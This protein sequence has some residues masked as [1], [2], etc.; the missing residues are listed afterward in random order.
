[1]AGPLAA[2]IIGAV[3][4][5]LGGLFGKSKTKNEYVVPDYA[6]I[7]SKAE[8]A[9]FN[10]LFAMANAPGQVVQTTSGGYMGNAIADASMIMADAVAKQSDAGKLSQVQ[11]QNRALNK[12][13]QSLTL[14][15]VVGGI[16]AQRGATPSL[17]KSLGVQ[18][19]TS[20]VQAA[21]GSAEAVSFDAA[22]NPV[23]R[24]VVGGVVS[25]PNSEF[26]DA[27]VIENRYGEIGAAV[28]G[29]GN[30]A[31][32]GY[33][34][35]GMAEKL[36]RWGRKAHT[37]VAAFNDDMRARS[38]MPRV[39][40]YPRYGSPTKLPSYPKSSKNPWVPVYNGIFGLQGKGG[41]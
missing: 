31:A 27:Q 18:D 26:S 19:D 15:P 1:M 20:S 36:G 25:T 5:L 29:L 32:D 28:I 35:F 8:A 21:N 38:A 37:R 13:V 24:A 6:G 14:R 34:T 7:R 39:R 22:G 9:G 41:F 2:P 40:L 11:A 16:Y 12:K 30:L 33:T 3:G 17:R 10:P 4:S 23:T